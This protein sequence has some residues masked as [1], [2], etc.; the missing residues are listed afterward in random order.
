MQDKRAAVSRTQRGVR[1]GSGTLVRRGGANGDTWIAKW[2][3]GGR[4]VQ[5]GLGFVHSKRHPDG[6]TRAEA[7]GT[8]RELRERVARE[9]VENKQAAAEN[10]AAGR[11]T[12]SDVGEAI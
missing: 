2:R 6:L 7:E 12:L 1:Y 5:R 11:R 3:D 10:T 9:R 4:Q 8:F